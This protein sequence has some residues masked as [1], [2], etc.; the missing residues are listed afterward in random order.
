MRRAAL[1]FL[2]AATT[3]A[4]A[5]NADL[6][7]EFQAG[8]DA[9]RLGKFDEARTHLEKARDLDPKLPGPYRFLSAVAQAQGKWDD[10][11]GNARKALELN[12]LSSESAD[13]R[14]VHDECRV[15]AGRPPFRGD[16]T[17]SAA[18]AVTT[19][20]VG[21]TVKI[22]GLTYGATPLAP[23][24]ITPGAIEVEIEKQGWKPA[25]LTPNALPGIV[26]D[27]IVDLEPDPNATANELQSQNPG[28]VDK[29]WLVLKAPAPDTSLRIDDTQPKSEPDPKEAGA[30][31]I[32]LSPGTHI[33]EVKSP[34]TDSWRRRV[35]ISAGQKTLIQPILVDHDQRAAVEKRGL[36]ILGAG[37]ALLVGGFATAM[38]SRSAAHEARDIQ[39]IETAR[40]PSQPL[41]VSGMVAP[42]RTRADFDAAT[43]KAK[44]FAIISDV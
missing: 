1:L 10:C 38:I 30:V 11:I 16:L 25:K 9:Y 28:K 40:D 18:V 44:T 3:I 6:T 26:T 39:R 23:R 19:N 8:V 42:V 43:D 2:V 36:Y 4:H 12:P 7:K 21:A 27:V 24:P 37:G 35:R 29:G 17:D 15:S 33:V 31:R 32:E 13:T 5:Q 22:N 41:S 34:Q 20:V 14:K